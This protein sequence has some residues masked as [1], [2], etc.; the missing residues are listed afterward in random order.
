MFE[1]DKLE[2]RRDSP[3]DKDIW[4]F[5]NPDLVD[6]VTDWVM[7]TPN[8]YYAGAAVLVLLIL[9]IACVCCCCR[10]C[11]SSKAKV[12][13]NEPP[14]DEINRFEKAKQSIHVKDVLNE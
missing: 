9:L 1:N 7:E 10:C 13:S 4:S 2:P 11:C 14:Q 5:D 8:I 6:D 12:I 3:A